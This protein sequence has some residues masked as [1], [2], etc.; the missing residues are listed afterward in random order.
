VKNVVTVPLLC[1]NPDETLLRY[2][3]VPRV[4]ATRS[5]HFLISTHSHRTSGPRLARAQGAGGGAALKRNNVFSHGGAGVL[6]RRTGKLHDRPGRALFPRIR[7]AARGP[8]RTGVRTRKDRYSRRFP[9][10]FAVRPSVDR[11]S[12]RARGDAPARYSAP[13][14]MRPVQRARGDAP[15][16][17]YGAPAPARHSSLR[18]PVRAR[19][20]K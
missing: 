14:K 13:G 20:S 16:T 10:R 6:V 19:S 18:V 12:C 2:T 11:S 15:A 5:T 17:R 9:A 7:H 1:T 3:T 4:H 8:A